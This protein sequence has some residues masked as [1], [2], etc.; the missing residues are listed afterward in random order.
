MKRD[1]FEEMRNRQQVEKAM[2][3][4]RPLKDLYAVAFFLMALTA[5]APFIN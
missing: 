4:Q 1:L 3:V 5:I 2:Q